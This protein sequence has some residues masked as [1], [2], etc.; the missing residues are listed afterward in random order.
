MEIANT[1]FEVI[2]IAFAISLGL[3]L[4]HAMKDIL[5]FFRDDGSGG[6]RNK[7]TPEDRTH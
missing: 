6:R 1:T 2:L 7:L 5:P 3:N 4:Y